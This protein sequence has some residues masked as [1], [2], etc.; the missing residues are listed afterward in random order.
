MKYFLLGFFGS[1]FAVLAFSDPALA[2]TQAE[3]AEIFAEVSEETNS[4]IVQSTLGLAYCLGFVAGS[5]R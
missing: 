5:L 2:L 4:I 1:I 3:S